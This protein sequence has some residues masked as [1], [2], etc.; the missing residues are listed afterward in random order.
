[1][2]VEKTENTVI[3]WTVILKPIAD[4]WKWWVVNLPE[5]HRVLSQQ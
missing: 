1:V 5:P 2:K 4:Q 3:L